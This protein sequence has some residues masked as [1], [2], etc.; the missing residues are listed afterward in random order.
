MTCS[1]GWWSRCFRHVF[2]F[3]YLD[4]QSV[5][6]HYSKSLWY[7]QGRNSDFLILRTFYHSLNYLLP[8]APK[9]SNYSVWYMEGIICP[10]HW[11]LNIT[12]NK[13]TKP[14]LQYKWH[15][16]LIQVDPN[17]LI[18]FNSTFTFCSCMGWDT[19]CNVSLS[20]EWTAVCNY[21]FLFSTSGANQSKDVNL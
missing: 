16:P 21:K 9:E 5:F 18:S 12:V 10:Q 19:N 13:K 17:E 2:C 3:M 11:R 14:V 15:I 7:I 1:N 20:G 4:E 6:E 8:W